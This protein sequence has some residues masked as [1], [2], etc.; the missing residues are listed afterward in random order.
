MLINGAVANSKG[1]ICFAGRRGARDSKH[2]EYG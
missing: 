1:K 2:D